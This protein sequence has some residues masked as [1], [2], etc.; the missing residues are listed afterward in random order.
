ML[1]NL[2]SQQPTKSEDMSTQ[3]PAGM[4]MATLFIMSKF[5]NNL[6]SEWI[7]KQWYIQ[8]M[9]Y[10]SGLKR[11]ELSSHEKIWRT[12]NCMLLSEKPI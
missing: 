5:G 8:K 3:K 9:E 6:L 11:N 2:F 4:F 10:D 7:N 1:C 12:F